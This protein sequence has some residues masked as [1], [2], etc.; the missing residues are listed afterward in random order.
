MAFMAYERVKPNLT[1]LHP[2]AIRMSDDNQTSET[3]YG[4]Y[5]R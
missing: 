4:A 2:G 1:M 5:V 3:E